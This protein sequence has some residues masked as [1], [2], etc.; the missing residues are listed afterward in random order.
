[1]TKGIGVL[2]KVW[3]QL[4]DKL[5]VRKQRKSNLLD[6]SGKAVS[7]SSDSSSSD[8]EDDDHTGVDP[9]EIEALR[10]QA[11]TIAMRLFSLY[12]TSIDIQMVL[13]THHLNAYWSSSAMQALRTAAR[14]MAEAARVCQQLE[15]IT[16]K[17]NNRNMISRW[18]HGL[19]LQFTSLWELCGHFARSFA[20]DDL[21]RDRGHAAGDDVVAVLRD[22]EAALSGE[23]S[24]GTMQDFFAPASNEPEQVT[25]YDLSGIVDCNSEATKESIEAAKKL[26]DNQRQLQRDRRRVLVAAGLA[27]GRAS[28]SYERS[29]QFNARKDDE[30]HG[31]DGTKMLN[32][33]RQ[34]QGDAS[35]E[36][37]KLLLNDLRTLLSQNSG[38]G[39]CQLDAPHFAVL[40][41]AKFWFTEGLK[42]FELCHDLQ[43]SV[44]LRCNLCQAF[45]LQVSNVK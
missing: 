14:T 13:A 23:S 12:G 43:N 35:N 8:E 31:F 11:E 39:S 32:L 19:R 34:R 3:K 1:L 2:K 10:V 4:V 20:A 40:S 6:D 28:S 38:D 36:L 17:A 18:K 44:L 24:Q 33:L 21:W 16:K 27:Y 7:V 42:A 26:L 22:V 15:S 9:T 5:E 25:L 45:K 30:G 29:F 37:A 41:S